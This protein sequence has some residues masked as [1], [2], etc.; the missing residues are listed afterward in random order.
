LDSPDLKRQ[1]TV[2]VIGGGVAALMLASHID[3]QKYSVTIYEQKKTVGRKF[4][5]AGEGGLNLTYHAPLNHII[6]QY[7]PASFMESCLNAFTHDD[8]RNWLTSI[9][10]ETFVGSS[11]RVFPVGG[12]KPITVLNT[13]VDHITQ[14]GVQILHHKRWVGWTKSGDL[15]F[16]SGDCVKSDITVLALGG[17]SWKVTGSN[18]TWSN[19]LS[20]QGIQV[21]PFQAANCAFGVKWDTIFATTYAGKPLKNIALSLGQKITKGELVITE[22]GLEGNAIYAHSH[23]IQQELRE[24]NHVT[25]YLDLKPMMTEEQLYTKYITSHRSKPTDILKHDLNIDKTAIAILKQMTDKALFGDIRI[26]AK[27]LKALPIIITKA[28][29]IDQAIST[30]GGIDL[31]EVNHHYQLKGINNCY[32]IGEMLDWYAPTGGYLLQGCFSMG[33]RLANYLNES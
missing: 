27:T 11:H 15:Q 21:N 22:S 26:L 20:Q 33:Y 25:M 14:K 12:V 32:A 18:G 4:L 2:S 13:I 16:E 8:L 19:I 29:A 24:G 7:E 3:T 10:I 9:G 5:V 30:L 23:S 6:S 17:A 1:K 28:G 31:D